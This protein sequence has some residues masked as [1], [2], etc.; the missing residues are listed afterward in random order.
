MAQPLL[1]RERAKLACAPLLQRYHIFLPPSTPPSHRN[2][3]HKTFFL[4]LR[5]IAFNPLKA[6]HN[7]FC[8]SLLTP[9]KLCAILG[10]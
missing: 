10:L 6:R 1:S 3:S 4:P 8:K 7:I 9:G 5:V 2:P